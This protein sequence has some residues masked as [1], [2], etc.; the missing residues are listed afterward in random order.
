MKILSSIE[1]INSF[2]KENRFAMVYF[3]SNNCDVCIELLPKVEELLKLY[4][5]IN[6][7]KVEIDKLTIAVGAFSVFTLPC[8]LAFIDE[9][10]TIREAR[11]ISINKLKEKIE[12]YY[13][14]VE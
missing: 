9:K 10:E 5:I 7:A 11:F 14:Y 4:P 12:R 3:S 6:F 2:I 8:I 13:K 1:N